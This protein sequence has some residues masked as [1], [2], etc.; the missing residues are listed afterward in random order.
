[1]N[2]SFSVPLYLLKAIS[3]FSFMPFTPYFKTLSKSIVKWLMLKK[4][5]SALY[6]AGTTCLIASP[7]VAAPLIFSPSQILIG[8]FLAIFV[9][10]KSYFFKGFNASNFS[11]SSN[12]TASVFKVSSPYFRCKDS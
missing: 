8:A 7:S 12:I 2:S 6:V 4:I 5:A 9:I 3:T 1:M 10:A 11:I